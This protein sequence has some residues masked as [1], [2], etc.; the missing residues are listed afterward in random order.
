M[1]NLSLL[2]LWGFAA[3]ASAQDLQTTK[4]LV[5]P[6]PNYPWA[7]AQL[8]AATGDDVV[9]HEG[10]LLQAFAL[11]KKGQAGGVMEI[12]LDSGSAWETGRVICYAPNGKKR[13]EEKV[14]FNFGGSAERVARMFA[15]KLE[16]KISGKHC[17][18]PAT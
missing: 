8:G 10:T 17:V 13:W 16:E 5:V 11:A 9:Y 15:D 4:L 2:I 14:F 3:A 7:A 6:D 1:K 18:Q 12:K